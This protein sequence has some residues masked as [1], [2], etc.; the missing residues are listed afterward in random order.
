MI[1]RERL[2]EIFSEDVAD[3]S[4]RQEAARA[5]IL[6]NYDFRTK[7]DDLLV[8]LLLDWLA[9]FSG[10]SDIVCAAEHD[11]IFIGV[12]PDDLCDNGTVIEAD[13]VAMRDLGLNLHRV[14]FHMSV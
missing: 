3:W 6:N 10:T 2:N 8:F 14:G 7:R 5:Y 1:T 4:E 9:P 12:D 11:E 13:I